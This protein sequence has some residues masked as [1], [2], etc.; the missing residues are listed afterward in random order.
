MNNPV[1]NENKAAQ[2]RLFKE[3]AIR[4]SATKQEANLTDDQIHALYVLPNC[5]HLDRDNTGLIHVYVGA[6]D[7]SLEAIELESLGGSSHRGGGIPSVV[8]VED[9]AIVSLV[10]LHERLPGSLKIEVI[11]RGHNINNV[12]EIEK[13]CHKYLMR[14]FPPRTRMFTSAGKGTARP[15]GVEI[16]QAYPCYVAMVKSFHT[17]S[18]LNIRRGDQQ[19]KE[20]NVIKQRLAADKRAKDEADMLY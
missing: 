12:D 16:G 20:E 2:L 19:D 5:E 1:N 18:S 15:V 9:G 10:E 6:G 7:V 8:N 13:A 17:F 14:T 4:D 3:T 11:Y